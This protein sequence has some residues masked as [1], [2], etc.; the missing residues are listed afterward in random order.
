[1]GEAKDGPHLM[2]CYVGAG[3]VTGLS[4]PL[5]T[6]MDAGLVR[7]KDKN[8]MGIPDGSASL[9]WQ[10]EQRAAKSPFCLLA[11]HQS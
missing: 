6:E 7:C 8:P 3:T 9:K 4:D 10:E 1:M 11:A 2:L 5:F